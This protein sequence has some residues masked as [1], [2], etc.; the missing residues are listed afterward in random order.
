MTLNPASQAKRK[1]IETAAVNA[2]DNALSKA[3]GATLS[4]QN[5]IDAIE[6]EI[7]RLTELPNGQPRTM[8]D[9]STVNTLSGYLE[10]VKNAS[11]VTDLRDLRTD[12]R[13]SLSPKFGEKSN[14]KGRCNKTN[15]RLNDSRYG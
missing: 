4:K 9:E 10:D 15:L 3:S 8:V 13:D 5:T 7:K 11:S 2:M 12:L 14:T 1:R 6:S